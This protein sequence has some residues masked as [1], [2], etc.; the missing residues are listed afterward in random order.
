MFMNLKNEIFSI[1]NRKTKYTINFFFPLI[2]FISRPKYQIH[3]Q[4]LPEHNNNSQMNQANTHSTQNGTK[5]S[6]DL[7][8]A[9]K[10]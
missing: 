8:G 4:S 10:T 6:P 3:S 9:V 5:T 1:A 2:F 7:N